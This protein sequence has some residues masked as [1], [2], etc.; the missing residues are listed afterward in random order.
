MQAM[1]AAAE[2]VGLLSTEMEEATDEG[3]CANEDEEMYA[4][5]ETH[6]CCQTKIGQMT[7][8][9]APKRSSSLGAFRKLK[10]EQ[11]D[12]KAGYIRAIC[13]E[14]LKHVTVPFAG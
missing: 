3:Q 4:M 1:L 6:F 7:P 14:L 11:E 8:G 13:A 10:D 2:H 5:F 12:E 9:T